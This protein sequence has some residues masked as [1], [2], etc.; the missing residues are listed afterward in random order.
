MNERATNG[1]KEV[2][3]SGC[4]RVGPRPGVCVWIQWANK[5]RGAHSFLSDSFTGLLEMR[6]RIRIHFF[7]ALLSVDLWIA[8]IVLHCNKIDWPRRVTVSSTETDDTCT[9]RVYVHR[10]MCDTR[11]GRRPAHN[12]HID[13]TRI[14]LLVTHVSRIVQWVR[15]V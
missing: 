7:R 8:A 10:A 13:W 1:R 14:T 2:R 11:P 12:N 3:C 9:M 5:I 4:I 15:R 6:A